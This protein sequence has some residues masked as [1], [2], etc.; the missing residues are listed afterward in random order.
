MTT[1]G[2]LS[3]IEELISNEEEYRLSQLIF[4]GHIER[5]LSEDELLTQIY[6]FL[7]KNKENILEFLGKNWK[8]LVPMNSAEKFAN[9]II[10]A[11]WI[12]NDRVTKH[13]ISTYSGGV[14]T[15]I[16]ISENEKRHLWDRMWLNA[17]DKILIVEDLIDTWHTLG[18]LEDFFSEQ[19]TDLRALCLFDKNV[20]EGKEL[21]RKMW[22]KL[23][24]IIN[25]GPEFIIGF[26]IDYESW[27]WANL[28]WIWR[29]RE[30]SINKVC[31]TL[32]SFIERAKQILEE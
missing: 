21:K 7:E 31:A 22:T 13:K 27:L 15:G 17:W 20:E 30:E 32:N 12:S 4:W 5:I 16:C 26:W 29:V 18:I 28:H 10:E 23:Q 25:I 14:S 3:H 9:I 24:S 8:I 19:H 6:S 2:P 11:L 1:P